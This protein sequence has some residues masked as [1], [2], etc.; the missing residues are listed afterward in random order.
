MLFPF[1]TK[2]NWEGWQLKDAVLFIP[3][4]ATLLAVSYDVGYFLEIDLQ[5]FTFFSLGEH[6]VFAL[7]ALPLVLV[8]LFV[9]LLGIALAQALTG[10]ADR[11]FPTKPQSEPPNWKAPAIWIVLFVGLIIIALLVGVLIYLVIATQVGAPLVGAVVFG[12]CIIAV[13]TQSLFVWVLV[14]MG[15]FVVAFVLGSDFSRIHRA[16]GKANNLIVDGQGVRG[17]IV[18][19]GERG[20]LFYD[21]EAKAYRMVRWADLK[22]ISTRT[23][24]N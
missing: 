15:V 7:M 6:I 17:Q 1:T 4:A 19:S 5:F 22:E 13:R 10:W 16:G 9:T 20:V 21:S 8:L 24:T 18:R 3:A 2:V 23:G 14:A 12:L 11:I